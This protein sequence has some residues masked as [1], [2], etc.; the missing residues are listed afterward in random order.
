MSSRALKKLQSATIE[1]QESSSEDED[2]VTDQPKFRNAFDMVCS[3][4]NFC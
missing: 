2:D 1:K 3:I 4:R